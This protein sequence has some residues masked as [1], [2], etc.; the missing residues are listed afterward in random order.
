MNYK[1]LYIG[2]D[3]RNGLNIEKILREFRI[4]AMMSLID[5]M[6]NNKYI[7]KN[8]FETY[9]I[10][11]KRNLEYDNTLRCT[12]KDTYSTEG[13]K[14]EGVE[15]LS[16]NYFNGIYRKIIQKVYSY[17]GEVKISGM[18]KII[19]EVLEYVLTNYVS[20][21]RNPS[22]LVN[23]SFYSNEKKV[24]GEKITYKT[25]MEDENTLVEQIFSGDLLLWECKFT[26]LI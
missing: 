6:E 17:C 16:I 24:R 3:S 13:N 18:N 9:E 8:G 11:Y 1:D 19:L 4:R 15:I 10:G 21:F 20:Q 23:F 7:N 12:Y 22:N 2:E 5:P 26:E 14:D 25:K